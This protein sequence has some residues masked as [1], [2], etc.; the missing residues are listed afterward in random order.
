MPKGNDFSP[1]DPTETVTVTWD[2]GPW[3]PAAVTASTPQTTCTLLSGVDA[4]PS[5][6]LIG[7]PQMVA[8]QVTKVASQAVQQQVSGMIAGATYILTCTVNTSDSQVLTLWA[9]QRCQGES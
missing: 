5:S 1:V 7:A 6:R 2:F 3:L 4:A 9:H 8:S